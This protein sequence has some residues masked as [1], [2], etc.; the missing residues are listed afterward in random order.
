[1]KTVIMPGPCKMKTEVETEK[2]DRNTVSI[3][4]KTDCKF[5]KPLEEE[6]KQV[7]L[8]KEC[9]LPLGEGNIFKTC[10]KYCKHP[11]CPIPCGILKAV[12][13]EGGLALPTDVYISFE[14]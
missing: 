9:F 7:D 11:S 3:K 6:L 10:K 13:A 4:I 12:E 1:M 8:Y 2:I 5:Y 14:K